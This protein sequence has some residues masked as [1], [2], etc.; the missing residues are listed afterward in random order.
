MTNDGFHQTDKAVPRISG[1]RGS[2]ARLPALCCAKDVPP[3]LVS[4][5]AA[6]VLEI[7]SPNQAPQPNF[8]SLRLLRDTLQPSEFVVAAQSARYNVLSISFNIALFFSAQL[9]RSATASANFAPIG[10]RL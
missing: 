7:V 4:R 8:F 10:V 3:A 9:Q 5:S 1:H 2:G 6:Q